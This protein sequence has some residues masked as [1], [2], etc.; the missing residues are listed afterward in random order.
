MPSTQALVPANS[1]TLP[2]RTMSAAG[3]SSV[4]GSNSNHGTGQK[5][6]VSKKRRPSYIR[7]ISVPFPSGRSKM[8]PMNRR[9]FIGTSIAAT[10]ATAAKP[11]WAA[12]TTHHI[13]RVGLQLYTVR[14]AMKSDFEGTIAKLA[15]TANKEVEF[16]GY[17]S[18]STKAI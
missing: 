1:C 7:G 6:G 5:G 13:D 12:D 2:T 11:S 14:D 15:A 3:C 10:L 18:H 16:P 17:L 8:P 4:C 9:T